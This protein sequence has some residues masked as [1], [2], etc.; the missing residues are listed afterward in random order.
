MLE[1][2]V[3]RDI[4]R[5]LEIWGDARASHESE[6]PFLFGRFTVTDAYFAPIVWRFTTY[7][8]PL[9]AP[10]RAYVETMRGLASMK[11]WLAAARAEKDFVAADE[12]YRRHR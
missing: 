3:Q 5:V 8:V 6:G 9:P 7:D 12:P 2:A 10:A 4:D 1:V 11:D